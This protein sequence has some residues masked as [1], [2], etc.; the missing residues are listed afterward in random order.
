MTKRERL[1]AIETLKV[2]LDRAALLDTE[3][4]HYD[5]DAALVACLRTLG[6]PEIEPLLTKYEAFPKWYA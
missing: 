5:A 6:G 2:S 4:R 3:S 1:T